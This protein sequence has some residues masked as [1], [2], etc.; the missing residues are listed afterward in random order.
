MDQVP[1][2]INEGIRGQLNHSDRGR[3]ALQEMDGYV[4]RFSDCKEPN[5]IGAL[6]N[7]ALARLRQYY[8]E[9]D[10]NHIMLANEL[11]L[12][13]HHAVQRLYFNQ[14]IHLETFN[15]EDDELDEL[16]GML[17]KT[18]LEHGATIFRDAVIKMEMAEDRFEVMD[19]Y[20]QAIALLERLYLDEN[21]QRDLA[22][23]RSL[24]AL[25]RKK[26]LDSMD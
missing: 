23:W 4:L 6:L 22:I 11:N 1:I 20:G 17:D 2:K 12:A 16:K 26:S 5:E 25:R 8:P 19:I 7:Q 3:K 10:R 21:D 9:G 15:Y 14:R 13:A 24:L 18:K